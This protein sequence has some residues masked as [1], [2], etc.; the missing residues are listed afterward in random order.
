MSACV[1]CVRSCVHV[2]DPV[3]LRQDMNLFQAQSA[4]PAGLLTV[5]EQTPGLIHHEDVTH[6]LRDQGCIVELRWRC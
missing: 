5:L 4:L 6:V 1:A 3:L 2:P